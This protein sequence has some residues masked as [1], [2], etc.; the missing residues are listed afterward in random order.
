MI[1]T[2]RHTN[3]YKT[4]NLLQNIHHAYLF[5]SSDKELNNSIAMSFA[6]ELFCEKKC[7]CNQCF[8][9]K[10]FKN[11]SHPDFVLI[12][13][14]SVK[15]EDV[16]NIISKLDTK[17]ISNDKKVFVILN[18]ENI[19]EIAQNKL[20][21]SLEEPN[22]STIFILTTCKV[23]KLLPT[24]L[25]RLHKITIPKLSKQDKITI[26][27]ELQSI[28]VNVQNYIESNLSLTDIINFEID[29]NYKKTMSALSYLFQ[30]LKSSQDIPIVANNLPEYDKSLFL[31]LMQKVF[32]SIINNEKIF[33]Q[34]LSQTITNNFSKKVLVKCLPLIEQAYKKQLSNVNFGY[35]LDNL[36]F[37]IL[38]EK[39]LC[40]Q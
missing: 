16:S 30:N 35:I 24:V 1:E 12:D 11:L 40:N 15:V 22:S 6:N 17:P 8:G 38:K 14:S 3:L 36:L 13:Q 10:Q 23:D 9:C 7:N 21:K 20:L 19:N 2:I 37:N 27:N 34:T 25:S 32:I 29:E 26:S 28:G 33:D 4:L 31:M 18:S 39:F 5:S